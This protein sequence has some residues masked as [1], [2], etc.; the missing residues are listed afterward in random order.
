MESTQIT[1]GD[2][3]VFQTLGFSA[4]EGEVLRLRSELVMKVRQVIE[5]RGLTQTAAAELLGVT[6]PRVSDL[7]RGKLHRFSLDS[8]IHMLARAQVRLEFTEKTARD[9]DSSRF[10]Q[11]ET[12]AR[13]PAI[14]W[15]AVTA[16]E[17][18]DEG[19]SSVEL[20]SQREVAATRV[21]AE[22]VA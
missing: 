12:T 18:F 14:H 9:E 5:S 15:G 6:Q 2:S 19:L 17:T 4:E 8:L 21:M 1:N 11:V 7:V 22:T 10:V 3:N 16:I 20:R 13:S